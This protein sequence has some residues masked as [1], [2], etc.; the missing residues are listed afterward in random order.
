M[1]KEGINMELI[2]HM[3][4]EVRN[5]DNHINRLEQ[6]ISEKK[7]H[8]KGLEKA[9]KQLMPACEKQEVSMSK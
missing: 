7:R 5:L 4:K 2:E 8:K 9:L 3:K 6:E 1:P